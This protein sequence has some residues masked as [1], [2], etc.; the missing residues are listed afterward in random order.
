M[1]NKV[2]FVLS[3]FADNITILILVSSLSYYVFEQYYK[4]WIKPLSVTMQYA[5]NTN[6]KS[7]YKSA[8]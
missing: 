5:G 2:E 7:L 8:N 1:V 4:L 3:I 6:I